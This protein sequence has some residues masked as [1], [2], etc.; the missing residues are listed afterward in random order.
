V[1]VLEVHRSRE[2]VALRSELDALRRDVD[3]IKHRVLEDDLL[4]QLKA[5]EDAVST[6]AHAHVCKFRSVKTITICICLLHV[7][8]PFVKF[9]FGSFW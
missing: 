2:V 3:S 6:Y 7:A 1:L 4:E 9:V 5:F 8:G